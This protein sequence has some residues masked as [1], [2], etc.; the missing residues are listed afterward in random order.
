MTIEALQQVI[1][2]MMRSIVER[3][4]D[5]DSRVIEIQQTNTTVD[6]EI[7]ALKQHIESFRGEVE[8]AQQTYKEKEALL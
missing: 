7:E 1:D 6:P 2:K 3:Q 5:F 4:T 8:Q